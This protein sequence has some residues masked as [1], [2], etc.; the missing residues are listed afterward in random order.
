MMFLF[1]TSIPV[2]LLCS[3]RSVALARLR[4]YFEILIFL[5]QM[6]ILVGLEDARGLALSTALRS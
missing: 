6:E 4:E 2:V 3:T 5:V 1:E